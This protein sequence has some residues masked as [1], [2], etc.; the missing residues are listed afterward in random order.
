VAAWPLLSDTD[1]NG[2]AVSYAYVADYSTGQY[3]IQ[4]ISYGGSA[5]VSVVF[6]YENRPDPT[7][8][9]ASGYMSKNAVRLTTL[10]TRVGSGKVLTYTIGYAADP[11]SQSRVA[12]ITVCAATGKCLPAKGVTSAPMDVRPVRSEWA[13]PDTWGSGMPIASL[14]DFDGDGREDI[15]TFT[16][17]T[18]VDMK[19]STGSAFVSSHVAIPSPGLG[20]AHWI[21][22]FDGDPR[23]EIMTAV[24]G[25]FYGYKWNG[26]AWVNMAAFNGQDL[27]PSGCCHTDATWV[28]D[29]NGDGL[30]DIATMIGST[31]Y[32]MFTRADGGF[33]TIMQANIA[34]DPM[35]GFVWIGD[36][37]GNGTTDIAWMPGN[38]PLTML[39]SDGTGHWNM[40][41][42]SVPACW[43]TVGDFFAADVNGDGRT[44]IVAVPGSGKVWVNLSTGTG[45]SQFTWTPPQSLTPLHGIYPADMNGD[46]K[47]DIVSIQNGTYYVNY[48]TGTGFQQVSYPM[49]TWSNELPNFVADFDGDGLPDIGSAD[50]AAVH[51]MLTT[52]PNG[53]PGLVNTIDNGFGIK[54]SIQTQSLT[55]AR[56]GAYVMHGAPIYPLLG[57]L[58]PTRVVTSIARDN[59]GTAERTTD[60]Y[61]YE[62]GRAEAGTGRGFLGFAKIVR[63][64]GV[65]G[66]YT[67]S[68]YQQTSPD[69]ADPA[70]MGQTV[71]GFSCKATR[72]GAGLACPP[73]HAGDTAGAVFQV[74]PTSDTTVAKDLDGSVLPTMDIGYATPDAYGNFP[75][76]TTTRSL[77]DG[78]QRFVTTVSTT[79][80]NDPATW[81]IGLPLKSTTTSSALTV[82]KTVLPG[83]GNLPSPPSVGK[84]AIVMVIIE[85]LLLGD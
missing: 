22:S 29:F 27:I 11:L 75:T 77:P 16:S 56:G 62:D 40:I 57:V 23:A 15:V 59:P 28:G 43:T 5:N 42:S 51:M 53:F 32:T 69:P 24:N 80:A 63:K 61:T 64:D 1:R 74:Y 49:G 78:S 2:N 46:G 81:R 55:Q 85:S 9:Y 33:T 44:D 10:T 54:T 4:G 47:V 6:G 26:S 58:S 35:P 68:L 38:N 82:P 70:R 19:L 73:A 25:K 52:T 36:F 41:R 7:T 3:Y 66:L 20:T 17:P 84:A 18:A 72:A 79:Y 83:S 76:V 60:S 71:H 50:G 8:R 13:T 67:T 39:L 31:M 48:S 12:S 21:G 37:D 14:G 45:W 34:Y 30:T 65:S